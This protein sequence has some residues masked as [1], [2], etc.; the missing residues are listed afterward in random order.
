MPIPKSADVSEITTDLH[1]LSFRDA[2][3]LSFTNTHQPSLTSI[4][5]RVVA[6]EKKAAS[7]RYLATSRVAQGT[8]TTKREIKSNFKIGVAVKVHGVVECKNCHKPHCIYSQLAISQTN[9]PLPP[10]SL[11][12]TP[13]EQLTS[14]Q[15]Q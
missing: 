13:S 1:Y 3:L 5:L 15:V 12:D 9:P 6:R 2:Q 14:Q 11:D 8:V 10:P 4:A 7:S